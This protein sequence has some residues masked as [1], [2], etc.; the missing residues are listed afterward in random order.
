MDDVMSPQE[1][2]PL[3]EEEIETMTVAMIKQVSGILDRRQ[4]TF[5]LA[6]KL[7]RHPPKTIL[8]MFHLIAVG[9][10]FKVPHFQDAFRAVSDVK[11]MAKYLGND[12]MSEIYTLARSQGRTEVTSFMQMMPAARKLGVDEEL[13]EDPLLK[14]MALGTKRQKARLRDRDLLERLCHEQDPVV[15][16]H[17]LKNP[18][19]SLRHVVRIASKRPTGAEVL[20]VVYRDQRWVNHY[21][22]KLALVN[23]PYT[24]TQI[25]VSLLNFLLEQDLEDVAENMLLHPVVKQTAVD[26]IMLKRTTAGADEDA[27][28]AGPG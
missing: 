19:V 6:S 20:R 27:E 5:A 11:M 10:R 1:D 26:L 3:S 28:N 2:K 23:N 18:V 24:P 14:E 4:R 22:V 13:E 16:E 17:L 9:A 25:S 12:L 15:I 21:V 7:K 8:A